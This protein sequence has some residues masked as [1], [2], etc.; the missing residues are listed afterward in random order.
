MLG[1]VFIVASDAAYALP[2]LQLDIAGG[3]YNTLDQTIY[4]TDSSFKLYALLDTTKAKATD[5][6]QKYYI[7][8]AVSPQVG[9]APASLGSFTF[10]GST[11]DVTSDMVYG[12]P[13]IEMDGTAGSDPGD[14]PSHGIFDTFFTEFS[15]TFNIAKRA[16]A[17]NSQ[18][19][20]GGLV[21]N[22]LGALLY[23]DFQ[24]DTSG[25]VNGYTIHFDLY[26]EKYCL[27]KKGK[28]KDIDINQK[29]PFSHDANSATSVPEPATMLLLGTG[30]AGFVL[31]GKRKGQKN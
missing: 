21:A 1:L 26:S 12:V 30:L 7:S 28:V 16:T 25:L 2:M 14:L 3:V 23:A 10:G 20:P 15:F 8:A 29:A 6:T 5:I 24:V 31:A 18:N 11:I 19:T 17:Y 13:P 4:A 22:P 9:P 27:D